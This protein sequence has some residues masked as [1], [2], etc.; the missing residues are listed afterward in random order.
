[1]PGVSV[2]SYGHEV[3][4]GGTIHIQGSDYEHVQ[5]FLDGMRWNDISS[6]TDLSRAETQG[7]G[8]KH[9]FMLRCNYSA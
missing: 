2:G 9:S 7:R 1:M 4:N 6:R 3:N 5:V 8:E